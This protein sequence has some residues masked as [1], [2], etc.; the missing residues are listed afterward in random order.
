[1]TKIVIVFIM[2]VIPTAILA[3]RR[4]RNPFLWSVLCLFLGPVVFFILAMM[5]Y[6]CP[7]C[8]KAFAVGSKDGIHCG[9]CGKADKVLKQDEERLEKIRA[10][11]AEH[12]K[13]LKCRGIKFSIVGEMGES[14]QV[15]GV[16]ELE[17]YVT[18]ALRR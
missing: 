13:S 15:V 5:H 16:D 3:V 8:G 6:L 12:R 7:R 11:L 1:M 14:A 9:Y 10:V 18:R 2:F 17:S 4:N